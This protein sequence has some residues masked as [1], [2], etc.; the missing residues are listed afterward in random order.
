MAP[1]TPSPAE[2]RGV[3]GVYDGVYE[4]VGDVALEGS[5]SIMLSTLHVRMLPKPGTSPHSC[6]LKRHP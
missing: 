5:K 6:N 3:G 1:S 2:E 4:E